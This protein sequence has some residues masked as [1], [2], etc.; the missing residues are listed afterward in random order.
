MASP[1]QIILFPLSIEQ[2]AWDYNGSGIRDTSHVLGISQGTVIKE[3]KKEPS[4][5]FVNHALLNSLL[6]SEITVDIHK[7]DAV[8]LDEMLSY[9]GSK[10]NQ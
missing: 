7:V 8:E 10:E 3:I 9:V 1:H 5:E 4:L 2:I 6:L